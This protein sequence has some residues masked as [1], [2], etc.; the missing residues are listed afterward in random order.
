M[1]YSALTGSFGEF[2]I[3]PRTLSSKH[4][5]RLVSLEGIV[6]HQESPLNLFSWAL[7]ALPEGHSMLFGET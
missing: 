3:N 4:L 5:N 2:A 6:G 1:F 7:T